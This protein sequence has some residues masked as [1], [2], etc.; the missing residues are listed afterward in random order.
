MLLYTAHKVKLL[1]YVGR[2]FKAL[3]VTLPASK[4]R[5]KRVKSLN[6]NTDFW[7]VWG[8]AHSFFQ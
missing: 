3:K 5:R 8:V 2:S 1:Y 4:I 7:E 6:P